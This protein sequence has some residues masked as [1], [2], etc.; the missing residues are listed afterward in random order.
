[1][2][3]PSPRRRRVYTFD[4]PNMDDEPVVLEINGEEIF[5]QPYMDGLEVL[6]VSAQ[7]RPNVPG[8]V[9]SDACVEFLREAMLTDDDWKKFRTVIGTTRP[10]VHQVGSIV[11]DLIEEYSQVRPTKSPESSSTGAATTG[12]GSRAVSGSKAST[13]KSSKPPS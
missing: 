10:A 12:S 13:R 1:M 3:A 11:N 6:A 9:Q 8:S 4:P 5:C 7:M 2:T